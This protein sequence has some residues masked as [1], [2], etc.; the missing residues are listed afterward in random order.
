M[1]FFVFLIILVVGASLVRPL[2]EAW[3]ARIA[4]GGQIPGE[5]RIRALEAELS[6]TRARLGEAEEQ[7]AGLGE[8]VEFVESLLAQP[9]PRATLPP[10]TG[11]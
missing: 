5:E 9:A 1:P 7:L 8:K 3:A 4:R 2:I 10:V 11:R 6:A